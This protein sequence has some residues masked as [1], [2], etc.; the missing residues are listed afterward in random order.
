MSASSS[1]SENY[2]FMN[3]FPTDFFPVVLGRTAVAINRI[4]IATIIDLSDGWSICLVFTRLGEARLSIWK[5]HLSVN[6]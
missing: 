1:V 3:N 5:V 6:C 2:A 4:G